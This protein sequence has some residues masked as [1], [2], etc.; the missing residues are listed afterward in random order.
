VSYT[1]AI[2]VLTDNASQFD[3]ALNHSFSLQVDDVDAMRCRDGRLQYPGFLSFLMIALPMT[4]ILLHD[5]AGE[6]IIDA[7]IPAVYSAILALGAYLYSI[8]LA[9]LLITFCLALAAANYWRFVYHPASVAHSRRKD[10][11]RRLQYEGHSTSKFNRLRFESIKAKKSS[12]STS[13]PSTSYLRRMLNIIKRSIQHGV[14]L[15]SVRR[16]RSAKW[17]AIT[18]KWS[19][20]NRPSLSQEGSPSQMSPDSVNRRFYRAK[21]SY[22]VPE[23]II[24]MLAA[25]SSPKLFEEKQRR[26]SFGA[27][28]TSVVSANSEH[29][30]MTASQMNHRRAVTPSIIFTSKDAISHLRSRLTEPDGHGNAGHMDVT[31]SSLIAEFRLMLDIFYPDGVALSLAE[32]T[33]A[34]DQFND[35]KD[36]VNDH[37]TLRFDEATALEVRMIR[38]SIFE[39]WFKTEISS[40]LQ[41]NLSDRLLDNS[42]RHVPNIKK[43][44][45]RIDATLLRPDS[46]TYVK[47]PTVVAPQHLDT[48]LNADSILI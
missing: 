4:I 25:A 43:R 32:K 20:M 30:V 38:F 7:A 22:R 37:F 9:A 3:C 19:C 40:I 16:T 31:E 15:L 41:N 11:L 46:R 48:A 39:E 26:F 42:L 21:S 44:L 18:K 23:K 36:S 17:L 5:V 14:T 24:N 10:K 6:A 47:S 45:A 12:A 8:S 13:K 34:C 35:W 27:S 28:M 33:E 29:V 2:N 1:A